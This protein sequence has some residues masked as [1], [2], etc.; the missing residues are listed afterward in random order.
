MKK[1]TVGIDL[2]T[3]SRREFLGTVLKGGIA[4]T[5]VLMLPWDLALAQTKLQVGTMKIGDLSPFFIAQEKGV[6]RLPRAAIS[7]T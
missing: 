7:T 2:K 5:G 6:F 1:I 3:L 4:T